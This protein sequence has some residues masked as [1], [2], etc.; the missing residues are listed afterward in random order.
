MKP[1]EAVRQL[2]VGCLKLKKAAD[3]LRLPTLSFLLDMAALEA[4]NHEMALSK[5]CASPN[6]RPSKRRVRQ[7]A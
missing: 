7:A 4:V 2:G 5:I 6:V 3:E 1:I